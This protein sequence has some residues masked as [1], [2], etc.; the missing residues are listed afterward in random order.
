MADAMTL[1]WED[2]DS[3]AFPLTALLGKDQGLPVQTHDH[4]HP[5]VALYALVL[6]SDGHVVSNTYFPASSSQFANATIQSG[7]TQEPGETQP[8]CLASVIKEQGF[9][10]RFD[11]PQR[12]Y[13]KIL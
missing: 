1:S 6:G 13:Q 3:F 10:A 12:L 4:Q 11:V 9:E 5:W 8:A 7:S 2:L